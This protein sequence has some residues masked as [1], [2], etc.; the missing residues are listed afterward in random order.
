VRVL[1]KCHTILLGPLEGLISKGEGKVLELRDNCT[2]YKHVCICFLKL[3]I[4]CSEEF[5]NIQKLR[6]FVDSNV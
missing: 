4:L 1:C 6:L 5:M 3:A 2:E